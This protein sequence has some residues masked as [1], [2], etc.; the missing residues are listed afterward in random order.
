MVLGGH[1][2][3][4][5]QGKNVGLKYGGGNFQDVI[6]HMGKFY[7]VDIASRVVSLNVSESHTHA[8]EVAPP[9]PTC[10]DKTY[11]VE[12]SSW[13]DF[14]LVHRYQNYEPSLN[15]KITRSFQILGLGSS[16][17]TRGSN[18]NDQQIT[19][20]VKITSLGDDTLFLGYNYSLCVS[21]SNFIGC[22]ANCIYYANDRDICVPF[23]PSGPRNTGI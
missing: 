5:S 23:S 14:L 16:G 17:I 12:S 4:S 6:Y 10:S 15:C 20:K 2:P 11:I 19:K 3:T 13:A 7:V 22:Q 1:W 18:D 9:D 8:I 21:A